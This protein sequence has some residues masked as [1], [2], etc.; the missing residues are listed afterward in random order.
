[1]IKCAKMYNVKYKHDEIYENLT[2]AQINLSVMMLVGK[3]LVSFFFFLK[4][5]S[6]D[7]NMYYFF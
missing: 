7:Y 2:M 4:L 1:M 5:V 6:K 3:K